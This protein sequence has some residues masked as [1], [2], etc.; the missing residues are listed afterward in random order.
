MGDIFAIN[1]R[2]SSLKTSFDLGLTRTTFRGGATELLGESLLRG[3]IH[4][5]D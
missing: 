5:F 2:C 3:F 1:R 4:R